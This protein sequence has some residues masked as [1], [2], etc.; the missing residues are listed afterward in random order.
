[1][2]SGLDIVSEGGNSV[3]PIATG[4]NTSSDEEMGKDMGKDLDINSKGGNDVLPTTTPPKAVL[5]VTMG[6]FLPNLDINSEGGSK[7]LPTTTAS[8]VEIGK[9]LIIDSE[10]ENDFLCAA[11]AAD[12]GSEAAMGKYLLSTMLNLY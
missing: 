7:E 4:L 1:M 6:N 12:A 2:S 8:D 10:A 3:V 5:E 9:D 11:I